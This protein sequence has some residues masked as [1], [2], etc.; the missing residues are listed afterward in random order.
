MRKQLGD[1]LRRP[2]IRQRHPAAAGHRIEALRNQHDK[3]RIVAQAA[4]H[5]SGI[6]AGAEIDIGARGSDDPILKITLL[7]HELDE[8]QRENLRLRQTL[9]EPPYSQLRSVIRQ[10][11]HV[12]KTA[13]KALNVVTG[14]GRINFHRRAFARLQFP[15]DLREMQLDH[16]SMM[17]RDAAFQ[18]GDELCPRRLEPS[19][20]EIGQPLRLGLPCDEGGENRSAADAEDIAHDFGQLDVRIFERLLDCCVCHARL[21]CAFRMPIHIAARQRGRARRPF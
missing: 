15:R 3:A 17:R 13:I 18:R 7:E 12:S 1:F 4:G 8:A 16:E 20:R 19:V 11:P 10:Y 6:G 14:T 2:R 21:E 9:L 5:P